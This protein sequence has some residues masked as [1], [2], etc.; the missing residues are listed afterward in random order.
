MDHVSVCKTVRKNGAMKREPTPPIRLW[1]Y[2]EWNEFSRRLISDG[3]LYFSSL[4]DLNDPFEFYWREQFPQDSEEREEFIWKFCRAVASDALEPILLELRRQL[5]KWMQRS[6]LGVIGLVPT[7]AE[8][9]EGVFCASERFDDLL[10]WSHYADKHRGVCVSLRTD[11][12]AGR[13]ILQVNYREDIEIIDAW[14]YVRHT[15]EAFVKAS[16]RKSP[17]WSYEREWRTVGPKG[18]QFFP[19]VVDCVIVGA[20]ARDSTRKEVRDFVESTGKKIKVVEARRDLNQ[21]RLQIPI[22]R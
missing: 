4:D 11:R 2:R 3:E 18:V 21:Y 14:D 17:H 13:R 1:K 6:E 22:D 20:A 10:M 9:Q 5:E 16:I 15:T 19:D 12:M 7:A 8:F